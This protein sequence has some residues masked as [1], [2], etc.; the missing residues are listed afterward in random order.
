MQKLRKLFP[1]AGALLA[2]ALVSCGSDSDDDSETA[3]QQKSAGS[4]SYATTSVEKTTADEA[5]TNSL[6]KTGD[7]TVSYASSKTDVAEVNATKSMH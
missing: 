3:T 5:F 6:T 7:G 1:L 2:L 4:I